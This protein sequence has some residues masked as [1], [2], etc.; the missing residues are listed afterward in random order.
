MNTQVRA[1]IL[2]AAG[3]EITGRYRFPVGHEWTPAALTGFALSTSVLSPA[4]LGGLVAD[5]GDDLWREP[6]ACAASGRLPQTLDYAY[7]LAR[8]PG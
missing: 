2:G 3:F 5:F 8:R 7:D 6:H 1:V 4:A